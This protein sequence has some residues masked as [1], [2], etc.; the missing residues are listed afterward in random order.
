LHILDLSYVGTQD[1]EHALDQLRA[2]EETATEYE[3]AITRL[4]ADHDAAAQD[5]AAAEDARI[6]M[7]QVRSR[8]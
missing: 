4:R 7:I 1:F 8:A 3:A 2:S 5:T 6:V